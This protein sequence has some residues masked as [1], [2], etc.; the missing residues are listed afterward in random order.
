MGFTFA[1]CT[2][3][4]LNILCIGSDPTHVSLPVNVAFRS[5]PE[6]GMDCL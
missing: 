5:R 4:P 1:E 3:G 6:E 2:K